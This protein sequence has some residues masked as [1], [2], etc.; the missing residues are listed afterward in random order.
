MVREYAISLY[1]VFF[2]L[3]FNFFNLFSIQTKTTFVASFGGN[4]KATIKELEKQ[5]N[6]HQ[7]IILKN[8]SCHIDFQEKSNRSI[9]DFDLKSPVQFIKSIYHLATSSHVIVDNYYGFLAATPFKKEVKCVQLWHAA[10]AI[11]QFGLQDLTNATRTQRAIQRFKTVYNRFNH[12]VVG[13]DEMI[14]VFKDSFGLPEERY[15]RTGIPRTDFFFDDIQ[16]RKAANK[17]R[18][19]FPMIRDKKVMLYAPTYRDGNLHATDLN[20]DLDKMY[21]KFKYDY[22]LFLRLHPA[23][24]GEFA[25]KYPGF[26]Y[27]VSSYSTINDLLIGTD[28][29]ITDYS[30]IPFEYSLLNKP[31]IF[32]AYDLNEYAQNRGIWDDFEE[33]V[34]GPV[35]QTTRELIQIIEDKDYDTKNVEAFAHKWNKYSVGNSSEKLIK[36]LYDIQTIDRDEKVRKHI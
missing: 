15:I 9:I 36:T 6:D 33:K 5:L 14:N 20:I 17:L 22:V 28:I 10:G 13:S 16:K 8:R 31:M 23:V 4:V 24:N 1:L 19:D 25:N 26:I 32:Y 3:I 27:N 2:R 18:T 11:K 30:S 35:V 12:V 21:E 34:P 7:I 29:L